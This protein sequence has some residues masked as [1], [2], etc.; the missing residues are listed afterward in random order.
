MCR[1]LTK[2]TSRAKDIL[3]DVEDRMHA[4]QEPMHVVL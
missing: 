4:Q 2:L 1:G 3:R